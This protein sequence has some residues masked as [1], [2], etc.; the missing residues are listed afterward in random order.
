MQASI[1]RRGAGKHVRW[2]LAEDLVTPG[3]ST[4]KYIYLCVCVEAQTILL[5]AADSWRGKVTSPFSRYAGFQIIVADGG[6]R[7]LW[8]GN[9]VNVLKNGPETALRFGF[10]G[11]LKDTLFPGAKDLQP[12][13]RLCT[14]CMAGA[15]SLTLTYPM[16][17]SGSTFTNIPIFFLLSVAL[18]IFPNS[19]VMCSHFL[20]QTTFHA[21]DE[22]H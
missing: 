20:Q 7:A 15:G 14:A 3:L 8:R 19:S 16:E 6:M 13:Q 12:G 22:K 18:S 2:H 11:R 1:P 5:I 4:V 17:V 9:A 21:R 10:Y